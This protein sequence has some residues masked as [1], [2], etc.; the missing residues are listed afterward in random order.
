MEK[1]ESGKREEKKGR[2]QAVWK[3]EKGKRCIRCS[4]SCG[5]EKRGGKK[6]G[7]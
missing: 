6:K 1:D 7:K 3:D 2:K 5:R 4:F